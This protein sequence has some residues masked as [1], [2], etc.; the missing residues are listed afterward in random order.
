MTKTLLGAG[1]AL[2]LIVS[3]A[4]NAQTVTFSNTAAITIN[5]AGP[6]SPYPSNIAVSGLTGNIVN[7]TLTLNGYGH[8][9][10]NDVD[11][12]LVSPNGSQ[13]VPMSDVGGTSAVT[14]LNVTF[15]N[16]AAAVPATITSGTFAPTNVT[17]GDVFPAPAPAGTPGTDFTVFNGPAAAQNGNW[18]LYVVDDAT[19]DTGA[20]TGGWTLNITTAAPVAQNPFGIPTMGREAMIIMAALL[21]VLG[22]VAIRRYV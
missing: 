22:G 1:L 3:S 13:L 19:L 17:P 9:F 2:G 16:G 11:L 7:V 18:S 20:I 15:Q 14:G 6:G 5:D 10:P 21:L 4:V 12:L 8:T